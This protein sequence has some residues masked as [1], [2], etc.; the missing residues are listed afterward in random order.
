MKIGIIGV[1][2]IGSAL[3]KQYTQAGHEVKMTNASGL[4]KLKGLEIETGARATSL[5]EVIKDVDVLVI[6]IPFFEIPN[7]AK[8]LRQGISDDTVIIDTTNYYPLRD[9]RIEEIEN[10]M[11]ESVWVSNQISRPVIKVYN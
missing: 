3:V 7:L 2:Q 8:A 5:N 4:E 9:G 1:G 11:L 10:G 6:S